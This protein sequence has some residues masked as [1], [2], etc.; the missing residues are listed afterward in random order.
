MPLTN[1][2]LTQASRFSI[3]DLA[4][5]FNQTRA[6]Y[7]IP[8]PTTAERLGEYLHIYDVDPDQSWVA[9]EEG[10]IVGMAMLG[11][12]PGRTWLTRLG[13]LP[14]HRHSGAGE[15]LVQALMENT[16]RLGCPLA[17]LEVI[18]GNEPAHRLFQRVGFRQTRELLVQRRP[19]GLPDAADAAAQGAHFTWL[20]S[21]AA[22]DLLDEER[23]RLAWTNEPETFRNGGDAHALRADLGAVGSGW[24]VYREHAGDE[25]NLLSHFVLHTHSGDPAD[26]AAHLLAALYRRFPEHASDVENLASD[27]PHQPGLDRLGLTVAFRRL[28][29]HWKPGA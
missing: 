15:R 27:D 17:I 8:M 28:E 3:A 19:A 11:V 16:R 2:E 20:D 5:A 25:G 4:E 26:V 22:V 7:L 1:I 23:P 24:L 13:V 29:M 9:V 10:R 12:R 6:D 21:P 14:S 18:R